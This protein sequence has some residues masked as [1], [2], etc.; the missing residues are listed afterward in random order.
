MNKRT[1]ESILETI[2]AAWDVADL[3][4]R[5]QDHRKLKEIRDKIQSIDRQFRK[6]TNS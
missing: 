6:A 1:I 5:L 2:G 3:A 4:Y